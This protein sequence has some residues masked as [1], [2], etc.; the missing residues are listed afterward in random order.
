MQQSKFFLFFSIILCLTT[1]LFCED[2]KASSYSNSI[3]DKLSKSTISET[4]KTITEAVDK[5]NSVVE[6]F[7]LHNFLAKCY[8]ENSNFEKAAE[9]YKIASSFSTNKKNESLLSLSRVELQL[10]NFEEAQSYTEKVL[11]T[12][13]N[14]NELNTARF[15]SAIAELQKGNKADAITLLQTYSET[16]QKGSVQRKVLFL[17]WYI[18][19]DA[20]TKNQLLSDYPNTNEALLAQG[21]IELLLK[22]FWLFLP[23]TS[24]E[25][26]KAP[27]EDSA[28]TIAT[29]SNATA[30]K[31]ETST[32][33]SNATASNTS[34]VATASTSSTK[35]E[36]I[37]FQQ[38]GF[39]KTESYAKELVSELKE[40]KFSP[41]IRT[42]TRKSGITY[43]AVIIPEDKEGNTGKR[44]RHE[45]YECAPLFE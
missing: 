42:T 7:K 34:T 35:Y 10:G 38:V 6:K 37:K 36:D 11:L 26:Q 32:T 5:T 19:D 8:E 31:T 18:T 27:Q 41:Q 40:K 2:T 9:Q 13:Q 4:E 39:F 45:G 15:Y 3:I 25:N 12:S 1:H 28:T 33:A 17:L 21:K 29:A 43:Y 22:P 30:T 24:V 16:M 23:R 44:L 14:Q 20:K